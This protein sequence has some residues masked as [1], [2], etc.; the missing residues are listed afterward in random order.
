MSHTKLPSITDIYR[1]Q[2]PQLDIPP[3]LLLGPGPSNPYPRAVQALGMPILSHMD[4]HFTEIKNDIQD[5]LRYAWQTD[6]RL[7]LPISGTGSAAMETALANIV[8]QGDVILV[9]VNGYF[10]ERL[11]T[12]AKRYGADV[13]RLEHPIGIPFELDAIESALQEHR[14]ALFALIHGE[15]STGVEQPLNGIGELCRTYE[16]L[17]LVDAVASLGAVPLYVDAWHIDI[18]YS[19]SQTCLSALPGL[20]PITF[21]PQ[22]LSK[23]RNRQTEPRSWYL[24]ISLLQE[25]WGISPAYHH[26]VPVTLNYALRESL[27][28]LAQQGLSDSWQRHRNNAELLWMG[29]YDLELECLVAEEHRLPCLTTIKVPEGVDARSVARYLLTHFNIEIALG[30]DDMADQVWRIGLMG[31]NSRV[32]NV[33]FL[34]CALKDALQYAR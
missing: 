5:L 29:L 10:G 20:A 1:R 16:T 19:A 13:R 3:R 7:T 6:N 30:L 2:T 15:A 27:R 22:A 24:D 23:I 34:L 31:F 33:I 11:C 12:I 14:P 9:A 17:F 28:L 18:C 21:S 4:P 25:Y 8:E 26:S 32:E